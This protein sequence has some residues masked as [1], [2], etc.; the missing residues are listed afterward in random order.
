MRTSLTHPLQVAQVAAPGGGV[1]GITF[2]PGKHQ[3][4]AATGSWARDL[5]IDLDAIKAW[6]AGAVLTL[7][8]P[9]ELKELRVEMLG[10]EVAARG[11]RW[12]HLPIEDVS[13]PTPQ[14]RGCTHRWE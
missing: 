10:H 4:T 5:A 11:M 8:T 1:V 7:V 9:Q 13:T 3:L 6:G 2:C 12:F 14:S